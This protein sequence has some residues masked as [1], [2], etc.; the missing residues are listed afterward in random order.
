MSSEQLT[1]EAIDLP[2]RERVSLAQRL[3]ESI[4]QGVVDAEERQVVAEAVRRDEE[5]TSGVAVGREHGEV[6]QSAKQRFGSATCRSSIRVANILSLSAG[7]SANLEP[8]F[9][10]N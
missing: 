6:M 8:A 9:C 2:L 4:E 7:P 10:H 5:L 3:W 1:R